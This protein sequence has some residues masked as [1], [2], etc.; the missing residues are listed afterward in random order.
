VGSSTSVSAE[1]ASVVEESQLGAVMR[2]RSCGASGAKVRGMPA[3][4]MLSFRRGD[5]NGALLD[6]LSSVERK[7]HGRFRYDDST[8]RD[9]ISPVK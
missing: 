5:W 6:R 2:N 8:N 1:R 4:Q 3:E 9:I 7:L